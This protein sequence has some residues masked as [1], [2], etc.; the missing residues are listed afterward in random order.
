MGG[1]LDQTSSGCTP[2]LRPSR[3]PFGPP[4][5][6][7]VQRCAASG[8][9]PKPAG[10]LAPRQEPLQRAGEIAEHLAVVGCKALQD[11]V[12]HLGH[13]SLPPMCAPG[14]PRARRTSGARRLP[15]ACRSID[16]RCLDHARRHP[17]AGED[18]FIWSFGEVRSVRAC[19][20]NDCGC[21]D[22]RF[23]EDDAGGCTDG[24]ARSVGSQTVHSLGVP[25]PLGGSGL[26]SEGP[27]P[28]PFRWTGEGEKASPSNPLP[29]VAE[30][31][32]QPGDLGDEV[33]EPAV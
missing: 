31:P 17:R 6:V 27:S 28:R 22:P 3:R 15:R 9:R 5:D 2:S 7:E 4:Q 14:R 26:L 24:C 29:P 10:E 1:G 19:R 8:E 18:P 23:R 11:A 21:M 25:L 33:V 12:Q 13:A 20:A 30:E 16:A 32:I